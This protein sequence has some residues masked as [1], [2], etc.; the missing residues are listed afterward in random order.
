MSEENSPYK[1]NIEF[2]KPY[3]FVNKT[4]INHKM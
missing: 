1:L 4:K 2:H 3:S